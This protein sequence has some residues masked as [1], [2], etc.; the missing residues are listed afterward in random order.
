M[1]VYTYTYT[2]PNYSSNKIIDYGIIEFYIGLWV[3]IKF[4]K[5]NWI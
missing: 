5:F 2:H 3:N 1:Y 4:L